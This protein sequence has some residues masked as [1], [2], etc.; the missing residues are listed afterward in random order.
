[1]KF[2]E[3]NERAQLLAIGMEI[4]FGRAQQILG[5]LWDETYNCAPRGRMGVDIHQPNPTERMSDAVRDVLAERARQINQ[6]GW[7]PAHDDQHDDGALVCA[8][9]CY[10]GADTVNYP[11]NEPPDMWPW[12]SEWWKPSDDRRNLV[13][14]AALI[15]AEIS[16]IDRAGGKS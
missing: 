13:K 6:E 10:A 16:R 4:G 2:D 5:E 1:M 14:A 9:I 12:A 3:S 11:R 8:A 15:L 7:T